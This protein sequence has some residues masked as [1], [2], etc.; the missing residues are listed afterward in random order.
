MA[1]SRYA[2]SVA[3]YSSA[4]MHVDN[5][6][7]QILKIVKRFY[8]REWSGDYYFNCRQY[9]HKSDKFVCFWISVLLLKCSHVCRYM[10]HVLGS[11]LNTHHL[12]ILLEFLIARLT[13]FAR[14]VCANTNNT[15]KIVHRNILINKWI[16]LSVNRYWKIILK[17]YQKINRFLFTNLLIFFYL[18]T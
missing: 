1:I 7:S 16:I 10:K 11:M 9:I 15:M 14:Y 6:W 3:T 5:K 18:T 12:T 2:K 17:Q 13:P 8:S 4:K